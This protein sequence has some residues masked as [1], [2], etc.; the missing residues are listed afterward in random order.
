MRF[1]IFLVFSMS[2]LNPLLAVERLKLKT[3]AV[4]LNSRTYVGDRPYLL[5]KINNISNKIVYFDFKKLLANSAITYSDNS[6]D[7]STI[8]GP[9]SHSTT[10]EAELG[11]V[12]LGDQIVGIEPG[13]SILKLVQAPKVTKSGAIIIAIR[14]HAAIVSNLS[15]SGDKWENN[16]LKVELK[17]IALEPLKP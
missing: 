17:T 10:D 12:H 13:H 1:L 5:V 8:V 14:M 6:A 15:L 4:M 3:S 9:P 7:F 11:N 2:A 16:T